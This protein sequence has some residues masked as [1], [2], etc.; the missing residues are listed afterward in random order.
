MLS[1]NSTLWVSEALQKQTLPSF[2]RF[3]P[4]SV[5]LE[6]PEEEDLLYPHVLELNHRGHIM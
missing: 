3:D 4:P 2:G 6:L 1:F 5:M